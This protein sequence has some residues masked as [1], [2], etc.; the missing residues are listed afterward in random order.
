M[1]SIDKIQ[2]NVLNGMVLDDEGKWV[3]LDSRMDVVKK[4]LEQLSQ[5]R[6][7]CEGQWLPILEAKIKKGGV[8][9]PPDT[10][11]R[12]KAFIKRQFPR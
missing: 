1:D 3:P 9:P 8:A 6:V 11:T 10:K 7:L 2:Q 4:I 5:G 12:L